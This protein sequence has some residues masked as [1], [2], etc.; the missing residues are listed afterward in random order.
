MSRSWGEMCGWQKQQPVQMLR[1]KKEYSTMA[2][3]IKFST[4]GL[5]NELKMKGKLGGSSGVIKG[6]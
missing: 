1:G 2:N 3:G 5:A 4:V 6:F